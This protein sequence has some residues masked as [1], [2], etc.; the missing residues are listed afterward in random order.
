MECMAPVAV[1]VWR[2]CRTVGRRRFGKRA[3][4]EKR[5]CRQLIFKEKTFG[6]RPVLNICTA[7]PR[8]RCGHDKC[9]NDEPANMESDGAG[10][11]T[12][13]GA[14]L[15]NRDGPVALPQTHDSAAPAICP[16]FGRGGQTA[17]ASRT[18]VLPVTGHVVHN[19]EL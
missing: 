19:E 15:R 5:A 7:W 18:R 1:R 11:T 10:G 2:Q 12:A 8:R 9:T 16:G 3:P 6:A 14:V 17:V 4:A 13:V